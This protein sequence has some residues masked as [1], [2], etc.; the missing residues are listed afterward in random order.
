MEEYISLPNRKKKE[1]KKKKKRAVLNNL[2][3]KKEYV[4]VQV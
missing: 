2:Y 3:P 4:I 1:K